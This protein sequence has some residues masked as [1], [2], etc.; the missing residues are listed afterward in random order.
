MKR[1]T[2][3]PLIAL[4]VA[5]CSETAKSPTALRSPS[6]PSM[7]ING[8][9]GAHLVTGTPTPS[10][11]VNSD[12]S[13]TCNSYEIAGVGNTNA[14]ALLSVTYSATIDCYNPGVNPNNPVESHTSTFTTS[15]SSGQIEPKN[16]RL[17]VP[18]LSAGGGITVPQTCPN[19]NW[20]PQIREG[21]LAVS[22][23]YTVTFAGYSVPFISIT[24]P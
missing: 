14:E 15:A 22:Y 1:I 10:C 7:A 2:L 20:T 6:L 16:G 8:P 18:S 12:L 19:P 13:V 17:A 4:A 3:L 23:T 24:G 9:N 21:T 5:A 11:A